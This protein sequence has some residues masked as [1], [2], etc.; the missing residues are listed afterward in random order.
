M[1]NIKEVQ[2]DQSIT[3]N[4]DVVY[5]SPQGKRIRFIFNFLGAKD[6]DINKWIDLIKK[7][8]PYIKE[9]D[10]TLVDELEMFRKMKQDG[11]LTTSNNKLYLFCKRTPDGDVVLKNTKNKNSV[12]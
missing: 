5:K 9:V 11:K 7:K 4:I 1:E 6:R 8:F 2:L 12:P 10:L 3:N